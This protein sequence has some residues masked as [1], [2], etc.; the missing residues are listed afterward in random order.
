[1]GDSSLIDCPHCGELVTAG[2]TCEEC[3]QEIS[4]VPS[5]PQALPDS[6]KT[7]VPFAVREPE[8]PSS[9]VNEPDCHLPNSV[10]IDEAKA[11]RDSIGREVPK[12]RDFGVGDPFVD[13]DA[14]LDPEPKVKAS[15]RDDCPHYRLEFNDARVCVHGWMTS[16]NFLLVSISD[17][18]AQCK[19]PKVEVRIQGEGPQAHPVF[20]RFPKGREKDV[21][22][23]FTSQCLGFEISSEVILSY[24]L[25]GQHYAFSGGFKWDAVSPDTP[26]SKVIENLVI[27]MEGVEAGMAADQNINILEG[28]KGRENRSMME[29]IQE[30][31]RLK[32]VWKHIELYDILEGGAQSPADLHDQLTLIGP[33]GVH[34]HLLGG[35]QFSL[36]R[37]SSSDIKTFLYDPTE[38]PDKQL[39]T[40]NGI[41]RFQAQIVYQGGKWELRDGAADPSASLARVKPS[42]Y[43]TFLNGQKLTSKHTQLG[44]GRSQMITF[45]KASLKERDTFGFEATV[46]NDPENGQASALL[47]ERTD[48]I[49]ESFLCLAGRIEIADL[50]PS[51]GRGLLRFRKGGIKLGG[52]LGDVW[53]KP[54]EAI[55]RNWDCEKFSQVGF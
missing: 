12:V 6:G 31:K 52:P 48:S 38:K 9:D 5:T 40:A 30:F 25:N 34:L 54:G 50:L 45:G 18:T 42:T 44:S 7:Q 22:F 4:A 35:D 53:L 17:E 37:G 55:H 10:E 19:L 13:A 33:G 46:L 39:T 49:R 16:F 11:L 27:K 1:M 2:D 41:S 32:P 15:N 23:N 21:N 8:E 51:V 3:G 14:D 20:G 29:S 36:G 26:S 47:L 28:F 43:G 24:Y